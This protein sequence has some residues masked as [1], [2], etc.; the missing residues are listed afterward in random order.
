MSKVARSLRDHCV[1]NVLVAFTNLDSRLKFRFAGF[2]DRSDANIIALD[3]INAV[4][5][6]FIEINIIDQANSRSWTARCVSCAPLFIVAL[7]IVAGRFIAPFDLEM[8]GL[9]IF[10]AVG[11]VMCTRAAPSDVG[12]QVAPSVAVIRDDVGLFE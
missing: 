4:Q 2:D 5:V 3:C 12:V 11:H 9:R 1:R 6:N 8:A 7:V 10:I